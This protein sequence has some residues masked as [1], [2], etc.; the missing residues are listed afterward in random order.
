MRE[1]SRENEVGCG[2]LMKGNQCKLNIE[3]TMSF[4]CQKNGGHSARSLPSKVKATKNNTA[5]KLCNLEGRISGRLCPTVLGE[6]DAKH[7]RACSRK[8]RPPV[9]LGEH[10]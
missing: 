5:M 1:C 10:L 7:L 6:R 2:A 3:V 4:W 9:V 8:Q